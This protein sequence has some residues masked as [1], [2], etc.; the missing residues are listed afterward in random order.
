MNPHQNDE[1]AEWMRSLG[2]EWLPKKNY[3]PKSFKGYWVKEVEGEPEWSLTAQQAAFFY[4]AVAE[5]QQ[6][7]VAWAIGVIDRQHMLKGHSNE[8][9]RLFKGIKNNIR[10]EYEAETGTDPAPNYP[11]TAALRGKQ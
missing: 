1:V 7:A 8:A 3:F 6:N 5:A 4:A 11:I 2:F 9:D 10:T